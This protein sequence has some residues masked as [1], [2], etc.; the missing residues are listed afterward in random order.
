MQSDG[1]KAKLTAA[2]IFT[3]LLIVFVVSLNLFNAGKINYEV[4]TPEISSE[5]YNRCV[6]DFSEQLS[7]STIEYLDKI[8]N[9]LI[10]KCDAELKFI[11]QNSTAW[12]GDLNSYAGEQF[13]FYQVR[14]RGMLFFILIPEDYTVAVGT[15]IYNAV[16]EQIYNILDN[17][18]EPS[19]ASGDYD[20]AVIKT[21][22]SAARFYENHYNVNILGDLQNSADIQLKVMP[23]PPPV[24][25]IYNTV[26]HAGSMFSNAV[27]AVTGF[28]LNF[29]IIAAVILFF[30]FGRRR[31]PYMTRRIHI[32]DY[33]RQ[34]FWNRHFHYGPYM[35]YGSHMHTRHHHN[36]NNWNTGGFG[37][38]RSGGSFGRTGGSSGRGTSGGSFGRSSGSSGRSG[39]S[40]GRGSSGGSFGRRK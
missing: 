26:N 18:L 21:A 7:K 22:E 20:Q 37:N 34:S 3:V 9:T 4:K 5:L 17:D 8:N 19:F 30:I 27:F 29:V 28:G 16:G 10:N 11:I 35:H 23:D 31:K 2:K 12:S 24:N 32:D 39:G 14:N 36:N 13:N 6:T 1:N 15:D 38:G 40:S 25:P 33:R